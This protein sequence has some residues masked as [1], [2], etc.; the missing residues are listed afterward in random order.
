[1]S[2]AQFQL[3]NVSRDGTNKFYS[4]GDGRAIT[5]NTF[6]NSWFTATNLSFKRVYFKEPYDYYNNSYVNTQSVSVGFVSENNSSKYEFIINLIGNYIVHN[7][8]TII[9]DNNLYPRDNLNLY[10]IHC[11]RG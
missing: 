7:N 6:T 11:Y 10:E 3:T 8:T 9:I 2:S 1:M 5:T 4:N